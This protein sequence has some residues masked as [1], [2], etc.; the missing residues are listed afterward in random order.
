MT[1]RASVMYRIYLLAMVL[2]FGFIGVRF[3]SEYLSRPG[4]PAAATGFVCLAFASLCAI[5]LASRSVMRMTDES[6]TIRT[7]FGPQTYRWADV[8]HFRAGPPARIFNTISFDFAVGHEPRGLSLVLTG[9]TRLFARSDR[10]FPNTTELRTAQL[11]HLL[12]RLG[13]GPRPDEAGTSEPL[14]NARK[15]HRIGP[16]RPLRRR[17]AR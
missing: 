14:A 11:V 16:T 6:L 13:H 17:P 15:R 5:Q 9:F 4:W 8:G 7:V 2:L 12:N 1:L 3:M 10:N